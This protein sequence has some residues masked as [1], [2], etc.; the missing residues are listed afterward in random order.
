LR[1]PNGSEEVHYGMITAEEKAVSPCLFVYANER[2]REREREREEGGGGK[3]GGRELGREGEREEPVC[4]SQ[5]DSKRTTPTRRAA[6]RPSWAKHH[7]AG[8]DT[9]ARCRR[10]RNAVRMFGADAGPLCPPS[11]LD[12]LP[13]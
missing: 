11:T 2:E 12:P 10:R 7:R 9:S 1:L 13:S 3:E 5:L 8:N 6:S 4:P